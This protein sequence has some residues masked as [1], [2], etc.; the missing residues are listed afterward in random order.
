MRFQQFASQK[1]KVNDNAFADTLTA[2]GQE[3]K[4]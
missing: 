1:P 3:K 2:V 4:F